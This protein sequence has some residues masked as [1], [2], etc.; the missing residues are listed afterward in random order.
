MEPC[1]LAQHAIL[2]ASFV[3][4]DHTAFAKFGEWLAELVKLKLHPELTD[5]NSI[6]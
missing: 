3:H 6:P 5:E 4:P 1:V 2:D